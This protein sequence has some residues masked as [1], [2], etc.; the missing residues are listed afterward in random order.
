[1]S[2]RAAADEVVTTD[3]EDDV[4]IRPTEPRLPAAEQPQPQRGEWQK[5]YDPDEPIIAEEDAA[6]AEEPKPLTVCSAIRTQPSRMCVRT[7]C[8]LQRRRNHSR[9]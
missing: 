1:M 7:L 4:I 3:D 8:A 2:A 9:G 5:L 6:A